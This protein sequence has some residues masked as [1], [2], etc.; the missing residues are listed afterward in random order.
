MPWGSNAKTR[1]RK[2]ENPCFTGEI[3]HCLWL[4]YTTIRFA[5]SL[6]LCV[7]NGLN[8]YAKAETRGRTAEYTE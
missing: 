1:R 6:R 5:N 2:G 4:G 8:R 7:K 3:T